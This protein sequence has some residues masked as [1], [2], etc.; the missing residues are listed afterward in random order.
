MTLPQGN[1]T[2][3]V[4][5]NG[6]WVLPTGAV[7]KIIYRPTNTGAD[8]SM[9]DSE[10]GADYQVPVGKKFVSL[11]VSGNILDNRIWII[12]ESALP[13]SA[14][15][16]AVGYVT[17]SSGASYKTNITVVGEVSAGKYINVNTVYC[18]LVGY[19]IDV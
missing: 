12:Y 17:E 6:K 14:V 7:Y 10:T 3:I 15:K 4:T 13:D 5:V 11:Q 9:H 18:N 19:E 2:V 8:T 1:P 16:T